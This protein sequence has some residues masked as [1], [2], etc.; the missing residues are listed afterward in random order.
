[1]SGLLEALQATAADRDAAAEYVRSQSRELAALRTE[2]EKLRQRLDR[3]CRTPV[4][5]DGLSERLWHMVD[6]AQR[7]AKDIVA[8]ANAEAERR[9]EELDK[10]QAEL[11]SR[12]TELEEEHRELVRQLKADAAAQ[13]EKAERERREAD[14]RALRRRQELERDFAKNL[15]ARRDEMNRA[16]AQRDADARAEAE[17]VVAEAT[18]KAERIVA[19]ATA[20]VQALE[21]ARR[22]AA[23]ELRTAREALAGALP[24]IEP[25]PDEIAVDRTAPP[26][27]SCRP[28]GPRPSPSRR[29]RPR[30][31]IRRS[32]A[33]RRTSRRRSCRCR[34]PGRV[35]APR[36][37]ALRE[38][39]CPSGAYR[40]RPSRV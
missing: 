15:A 20:R 28:P 36:T 3:V 22:K 34:L 31:R 1:M 25:L 9:R 13:A 19:E 32:R 10:R 6:L 8:T 27:G 39:S 30:L 38:P 21:E 40:D 12:R 11:E 17:R 35:R 23:A 29:S 24:L 4:E 7:E 16:L 5:T 37:R 2:N 33:S 18:A 14:E 26:V